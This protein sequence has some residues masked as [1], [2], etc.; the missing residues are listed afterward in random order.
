MSVPVTYL[1]IS[2]HVSQHFDEGSG[3]VAVSVLLK[4]GGGETLVPYASCAA[5]TMYVLFNIRGEIVVDDMLDHGNVK[6]PCSN[7]GGNENTRAPRAKVPQSLFS[8]TLK[9]IPV[10]GRQPWSKRC[11]EYC[12]TI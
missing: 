4:E 2:T 3:Q 1:L 6:S 11:Q 7:R 10:G 12:T 9:A 8:L 5:N